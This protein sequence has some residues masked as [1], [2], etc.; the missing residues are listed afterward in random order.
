MARHTYSM[1]KLLCCCVKELA[2]M[3]VSRNRAVK[4][5]GPMRMLL[6]CS[7]CRMCQCPAA[8]VPVDAAATTANDDDD[9]LSPP[10]SIDYA[11][12]GGLSLRQ[13]RAFLLYVH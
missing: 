8:V 6:L 5:G 1:H 4:A 11:L 2:P 12:F 10:L 3:P 9:F 13:K 7:V